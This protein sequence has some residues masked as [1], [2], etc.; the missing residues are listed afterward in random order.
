[1]T[2]KFGMNL[3]R[4]SPA[5]VR[6][7][8][9]SE[10]S[11]YENA[12]KVWLSNIELWQGVLYSLIICRRFYPLYKLFSEKDK[13]GD[14]KLLLQAEDILKF[15][16]LGNKLEEKIVIDTIGKIENNIPDT[17]DFID[18]SD[19]MDAGII[20]L[21]SLEAIQKQAVDTLR[22][23]ARYCYDAMD[24]RVMDILLP[25]GGAVTA[26]IELRAESHNL[27]QDEL[28]WQ[29][30]TMNDILALSAMPNDIEAFCSG[31]NKS[32]S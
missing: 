18:C 10:Y 30:K 7:I 9:M 8:T 13:W 29:H 25:Q 21:Y 6:R 5:S 1:M 17:E 27:I 12:V 19:A 15:W 22:F 23:V 31:Y 11:K 26:Q 16:L 32:I 14:H 3:G 20:H 24:R 28:K 4:C 2:C